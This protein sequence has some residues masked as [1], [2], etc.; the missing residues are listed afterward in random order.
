MASSTSTTSAFTSKCAAII[1]A[2]PRRGAH[3]GGE[4]GRRALTAGAH[5]RIEE[6][7][8]THSSTIDIVLLRSE[9]LGPTRDYDTGFSMLT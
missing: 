9:H 3:G 7:N 6:Q 1:E 2:S 8:R 4:A 5:K